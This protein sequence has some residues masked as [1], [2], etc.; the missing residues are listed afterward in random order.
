MRSIDTRTIGLAGAGAL[1]LLHFLTIVQVHSLIP[2]SITQI[3]EMLDLVKNKACFH[4]GNSG[5][6][7]LASLALLS[8]R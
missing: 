6:Q 4:S 2:D 3:P 1:L 7:S 8:S 5:E